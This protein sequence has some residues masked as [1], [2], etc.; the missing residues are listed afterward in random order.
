[1]SVRKVERERLGYFGPGDTDGHRVTY[2]ASDGNLHIGDIYGHPKSLVYGSSD[3]EFR[4]PPSWV[5]SRDFSIVALRLSKSR[6][7]PV[8]LAVVKIDGTGY[9][10]LLRD[11]AQGNILGGIQD[12][13]VSWSWD[14]RT[15]LLDNPR[16]KDVCHRL[17]VC[18]R[19]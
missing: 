10:E 14:D 8:T 19:C 1:M 18:L 6:T 7:R 13:Q 15:L 2:I 17:W 5:V 16:S 3:P 11:D 4:T 9:R 12:F